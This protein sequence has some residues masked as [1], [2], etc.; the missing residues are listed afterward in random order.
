MQKKNQIGSLEQKTLVTNV[1]FLKQAVYTWCFIFWNTNT[2]TAM[3]GNRFLFLVA[4]T[5][6]IGFRVLPA[7]RRAREDLLFSLC[8]TPIY[9]VCGEPLC[10]PHPGLSVSLAPALYS[11][12]KALVR[13]WSFPSLFNVFVEKKITFL[14]FGPF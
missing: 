3:F 2:P 8:R 4:T 5:R 7:Q 6:F 10:L 11:L 12:W 13:R 1:F 14:A 9:R